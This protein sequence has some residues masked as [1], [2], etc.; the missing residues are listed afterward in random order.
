[1]YTFSDGLHLFKSGQDCLAYDKGSG[2]LLR[3][4]QSYMDDCDK[5]DFWCVEYLRERLNKLYVSCK[6]VAAPKSIQSCVVFLTHNCNLTCSYC[7]DR[8]SSR[9]SAFQFTRVCASLQ[10][11][12]LNGTGWKTVHFFGGE[13][14]LEPMLLKKLV[15]FCEEIA[16]QRKNIRLLFSLTTNGTLLTEEICS[17]LN[18]HDFTVTISGDGYPMGTGCFLGAAVKAFPLDRA[19]QIRKLKRWRL[20]ATLMP[21]RLGTMEELFFRLAGEGACS[22]G[23]APATGP[24]IHYNSEHAGEW[25][26]QLGRITARLLSCD[27]PILLENIQT[28]AERI[29]FRTTGSTD[30]SNSCCELSIDTDGTEYHCH[31][32]LHKKTNV[33]RR[34][35]NPHTLSP[36]PGCWAENLCRGLCLYERQICDTGTIDALCSMYQAEVELAC[37]AYAAFGGVTSK[38][39]KEDIAN[40]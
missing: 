30:H 39:R 23:L 14:L 26:K 22:I 28:I 5:E 11:Y 3:I 38:T 2:Y 20:R 16:A 35:G 25:K 33:E 24:D 34:G 29:A 15:Y 36:C 19:E 9:D 8:D 17:F 37:L 4:P 27:S 10:N 6:P 18:T 13:P 40:G 31:R 12:L 21:E 32:I 1:M 7:Y